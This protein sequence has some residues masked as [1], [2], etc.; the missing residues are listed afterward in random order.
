MDSKVCKKCG[1]EK[2]LSEYGMHRRTVD[3]KKGSCKKCL[4]I[5][6]N[7]WRSENRDRVNERKR[8][9]R[10]TPD[11][12]KKRLEYRRRPEVKAKDKKYSQSDKAR[13]AA[14]KQRVNWGKKYPIKAWAHNEVA[15]LRNT[16][17]LITYPCIICGNE[18]AEGHHEDYSRPLDLVWYCLPHH[19]ERH[20]EI[21]AL[22]L[23]F[24]NEGRLVKVET[25]HQQLR[26]LP[27]NLGGT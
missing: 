2:P 24:N 4:L 27:K 21:K 14:K 10:Q 26:E 6:S 12:K 17:K 22:G 18:K 11:Q 7:K 15:K 25:H 9:T 3:G 8:I 20:R 13:E 16:G 19:R 23:D 1:V 5:E